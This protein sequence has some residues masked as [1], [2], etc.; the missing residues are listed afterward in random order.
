MQYFYCALTVLNPST[1]PILRGLKFTKITPS[2]PQFHIQHTA[3]LAQ[4][5]PTFFQKLLK[6]P[7]FEVPV[8]D[9]KFN[10]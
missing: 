7:L 4:K 5:P 8:S 10:A 9:H 1:A 2:A 6:P 3:Q